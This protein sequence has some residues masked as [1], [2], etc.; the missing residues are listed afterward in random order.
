MCKSVVHTMPQGMRKG[1]RTTLGVVPRS[2]LLEIG[3]LGAHHVCQASWLWPSRDS[4]VPTSHVVPCQRN[5]EIPDSCYHVGL[6][7]WNE[8]FLLRQQVLYL[9][10]GPSPQP[11]VSLFYSE[12]VHICQYRVLLQAVD[13][14]SSFQPLRDYLS[15]NCR[16]G[17]SSLAASLRIC[18]PSVWSIARLT[19]LAWPRS[20]NPAQ[21]SQASTCSC[22]PP[23]SV[24]CPPLPATVI[25]ILASCLLC[26]CELPLSKGNSSNLPAFHFCQ[27]L[28]NLSHCRSSFLQLYGGQLTV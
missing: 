15:D 2:T 7:F 9:L 11:P 17:S 18:A 16:Q 26:S 23:T 20:P 27:E 4:P 28:V 3:L 19:V 25:H 8:I 5:I 21:P 1:N 6:R 13:G 22:A 10:A 14:C 24:G 12:D